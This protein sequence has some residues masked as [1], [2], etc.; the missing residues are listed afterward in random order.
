MGSFHFEKIF[1]GRKCRE[2][3][4]IGLARG[5]KGGDD[6]ASARGHNVAV[7][8][9]DFAQ[10]AV[11]SKQAQLPRDG[12]GSPPFGSRGADFGPE[13]A[14]QVAVAQSVDRV[15][16]PAH[17][18]EQ[19]GVF[20]S[21]RIERPMAASV[22]DHSAADAGADF[23]HRGFLRHTGQGFQITPVGRRRD[24]RAPPQ[25]A[26][27]ALQGAPGFFP[28]GI[29]LL[30]AID[31]EVFG[32]VDRGFNAQDAAFF[33]IHLDGVA[34]D[35]VLD[36][37]AFGPVF[38]IADDFA[39][40][41]RMD[42]SLDGG[43]RMAQEA[44]HV[45]AGEGAQAVMHQPGIERGQTGRVAEEQI[46][47]V[48]TGAGSPVIGLGNG[49]ANFFVQRMGL[50]EQSPQ[51]ARPIGA[52]LLFEQSLGA[53]GVLDP[54]ET[55]AALAVGQPG[56]IHL[57]GEPL[58]PVETKVH[59]EGKPGLHTQVAQAQFFMQEVMI[60]VET[61]PGFEHQMN[62]LGPAVT[63]HSIR[64][65]VF[66]C[67]ED[68]NQAGADAIS[69]GDLAGEGF[70][71]GL[72]AGQIA[73]GPP[74]LLGRGVSSGFDP[75]G[76]TLGKGAEVFNENATSVE[77]GFHDRRLEKMTQRTAQP[78]TVEAGQNACNRIAESA[79]K[80]RRDAG[81]AWRSL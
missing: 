3:F 68:G 11:G 75:R 74:R 39:F 4:D 8:A 65:T 29:A 17:R 77:I 10:Q 60:E 57:P 52:Q 66:Q 6:F 20:L 28:A 1:S 25:L 19:C 80:S 15:F 61:F 12:A 50:V 46:R 73:E 9:A 32:F 81:N 58:P 24:L 7:R 2:L 79:K 49:A 16:A 14:A 54:N 63:T 45:G 35:G 67:A 13:L 23:A 38:E 30:G 41:V 48:L 34:I 55:V 22:L 70:L 51:Q 76:Q 44:H 53:R 59:G 72:T 78:Q 56:L 26:H 5:Q 27:A 31:A 36:P 69:P 62:V 47:G 18:T 71:A 37:N 64:Q 43:N 40:E 42:P 33:V 21:P